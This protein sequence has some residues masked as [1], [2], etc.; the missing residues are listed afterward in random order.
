VEASAVTVAPSGLPAGRR[1]EAVPARARGIQM[2]GEFAASGYRETPAL[3]RRGDGQLVK[4]TP[5]LYELIDAIDGRRGLDELAAELGRRVG[6]QATADDVRFLIERKLRPLGLLRQPDGRQPEVKRAN[7]LLRLRPRVVVSKPELTR[8]LT[9]PFVWL[10]GRLVVIPVL[11]AFAAV[12][13]WLFL[14]K[15]LAAP[16]HQAIYEPGLILV[17]WA[18]VVLSMAFHEIGHAAACRYGG[19]RPGVIGGGLYLIWPAFYTEVSDAYRLGRGG[20]LR[21]DLGGLYFSAIFALATAGLWLLVDADALLLVIAVQLLLMVRQ[22]APFI[23]ADGYHIVADLVGVPD[24]F[25][26][27]KPILLGMLPTRWGRSQHKVLKPW[28]RAVVGG[29]VLIT[30]PVLMTVLGLI[31][32]TFPRVAAT[33]WDSM[34][35]RW[36]ETSAYWSNGDV[37]GVAMAG[38]SMALVAL[39][40]LSIVYLVTYLAQR[41]MRRAWRDTAGRPRLRA[42]VLLGA[43]TVAAFLA[44]AWWP[45]ENYRPIH[46]HEQGPVPTIVGPSPGEALQAA[47]LSAPVPVAYAA[48]EPVPVAPA[49]YQLSPQLLF[50]A[51]PSD[52]AQVPVL[53]PPEDGDTTPALPSDPP[54]PGEPA[55][56][57]PEPDGRGTPELAAPVAPEPA[58]LPLDPSEPVAPVDPSVPVEDDPDKAWPF[59]FDPPEPAEPGDNRAMAVNTT[60]GSAL[61]DFAFSLLVLETGDPVHQSNEAI[62][63][64]SCTSCVTGAVAFQI[65]LIVGQ[66]SEIIPSNS[67]IALNYECDVCVTYAFAYQI[68]ASVTEAPAA[69]VQ[70]EL[71]AALQRLLDLAANAGSLTA[72]QIYLELEDIRHDVLGALEGHLAVEPP[73]SGAAGSQLPAGTDE[74]AGSQSGATDPGISNDGSDSS[75]TEE[76]VA[77]TPTDAPVAES[78]TEEPMSETPTEDSGG[79]GPAEEPVAEDP[80]EEPVAENPTE[81]PG[82]ESPEEQGASDTEPATCTDAAGTPTEACPGE[83]A[84]TEDATTVEPTA[85]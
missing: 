53:P 72:E 2:L 15:G 18:L 16:L 1:L 31:V 28:A 8:R 41:I 29:W 25:A 40:V 38:I 45:D 3:V 75:P 17:I 79:E 10:F 67:A 21:V 7:P 64:A 47:Q 24:L 36:A 69:E 65:V 61:W 81:E 26:H 57:A 34:G 55:P 51:S 14:E 42:L 32:L 23:R 54:E 49:L 44:W 30:V 63:L 27:V 77:E 33:A 20:R 22:L 39:P 48:P 46:S 59:P 37:A 71:E 4:L 58:P 82:A 12:S 56:V 66:V 85:P 68:V 84:P 50:S 62:A 13:S 74:T 6:K 5:L 19:A 43:G 11:L 73:T 35:L 60:D 52:L 76:P 80:A 9:A 78:P 70:R 83:T